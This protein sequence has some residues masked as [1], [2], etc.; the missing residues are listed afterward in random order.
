MTKTYCDGLNYAF[1]LH[2]HSPGVG[3]SKGRKC[4]DL[5]NTSYLWLADRAYDAFTRSQQLQRFEM[6]NS[7]VTD[8]TFRQISK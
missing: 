4:C 7:T 1:T 5:V 2:P 6:V 8:V 3:I